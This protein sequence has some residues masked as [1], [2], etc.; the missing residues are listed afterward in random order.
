MYAERD[1]CVLTQVILIFA[2]QSV[3]EDVR[4]NYDWYLDLAIEDSVITVGIQLGQDSLS[5]GEESDKGKDGL[6]HGL[7]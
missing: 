5:Y 3:G 4:E 7:M 1:N 2:I 6:T